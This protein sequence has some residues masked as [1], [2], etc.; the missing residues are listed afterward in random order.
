VSALCDLL[1]RPLGLLGRCHGSNQMPTRFDSTGLG[2]C[3]SC[4]RWGVVE[5][6]GAIGSH[7]KG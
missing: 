1:A 2:F 3:E 5:D 7:V 4:K 6:N